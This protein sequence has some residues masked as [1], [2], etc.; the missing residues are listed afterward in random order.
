M[1]CGAVIET[2]GTP[3]PILLGFSEGA[4]LA[5]RYALEHELG[6]LILYG[7]AMQPPDPQQAAL[8]EELLDHWG[9]GR[10]LDLFAPSSA[11]DA[12]A[13][14][15]T[16]AIERAGASPAMI[17]HVMAA[18]GLADARSALALHEVG[19]RRTAPTA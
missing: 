8:L 7:S 4:P 2:V 13:R 16:A 10:S 6:G 14:E 1:I 19:H 5:I 12:A 9:E 15:I 18:V 11:G 3:S 17:R